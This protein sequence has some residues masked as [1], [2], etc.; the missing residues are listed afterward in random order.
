[1]T[2]DLVAFVQARCDA[3]Q[4]EQEDPFRAWHARDCEAIPDL[5]GNEPAACTC[6]VPARVLR[7]VEVK[8]RMIDDTWGGPDHED[9]WSH[10]VRL[11][12]LPYADH[13][14][15]QEAWRP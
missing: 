7:E 12:A 4:A 14:D 8:R 9:M 6:G 13:P 1:M 10:H 15:F 3:A 2:A 11:L 5:E